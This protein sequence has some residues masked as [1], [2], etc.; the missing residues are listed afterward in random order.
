MS[1]KILT[2]VVRMFAAVVL[3]M[4]AFPAVAA[5]QELVSI[6]MT[7][8][9]LEQ[10]MHSIE[11]QTDYVFLNKDIDVKQ[12]VSINVTAKSVE[13]TLKVLFAG[14]D[15]DFRIESAHIVLF[16]KTVKSDR[17][18]QPTDN[19]VSGTVIDATGYPVI[20]V[21]VLIKGT[22]V[23]TSTDLDGKFSFVLPEGMESSS[24][25]FSC[26]GYTTVELPIGLRRVFDVTMQDDA[27]VME[28]TVVTALG[29]KRSEKALSYNVQQVNADALVAN[30]DA[31]FINSLNGKVA[32]LNINASSSGVGGA[33]K[34]VMRGM[35]SISQS[36]NALYVIDGVPMYSSAGEGGTQFDSQGSSDP[37]ADMNPDDIES[38]SVLT[39]AAA[40]AL[41]GS[42]AA[43]GAIVITTKK[44]K[45]GKLSVTASAGVEI[46]NPFVLPRFQNRYGTGDLNSSIGSDLRSWGMLMNE[47]NNP[48]YNPAKDYF[49]TGVT[50]T[51]SVA[52]STGTD[53]NQTYLSG[54]AIDSEGVVPNNG[55][56]RYNFTFR[57]TTA[58][59][60]D[61]MHLD[62]GF[63]Y[64]LQKDRNMTNQGTYNNPLVGA[65]IFP[66]SGDWDAVKMY[67][68][69]D[70][71]RRLSTQY[72]PIGDAG[73]TMQ[74]PYWINYRNLREN[75]KDRYMVNAALSYDILDWLSV[76]GR[77]RLD[78]SVTKYTEKFYA[79]TF[80]QLTELSSNG[81]YGI[82]S[83]KDRQIYA[84]ALININKRFGENWTLQANIGASITDM[85]Y[86]SFKNRGPIADGDITSERAGLANV[87]S[88][89]NL[90]NSAKTTRMQEGWREQTQSVFGSAEVGFKGTYYLTLTARNDWPSQLAGPHSNRKSFFYPSVGASVVLSQIIPNMPANLEYIK[91]RGSYA[92][93][94]TAFQ[95][96]IA[97]PLFSWNASSL[98][99]NTQTMYKMYD[100]KP[101]LT[102]SFEVGLTIRFL[103]WFNLDATYYHTNTLNQTFNPQITTG[104]GTSD[105]YIQS[106]DVLNQ[107]C[108]LSLGFGKDWNKFRWDSNFTFS[109]NMNKIMSLAN[110]I[111]NYN[112]GEYFSVDQLD[113]DGLGMAHFILREG[114][115]LGDLYSFADFKYDS[116]GMIV[117]NEDGTV[118]PMTITDTK[119][120]VKLGSVLPKANLSWRNDFRIGNFNFGFLV[121][122]RIGG[123]V[124]SSTQAV[125]DYY[126]V[127]EASALARDN[128]GV[129]INGGDL[130]DANKWYSSVG[131]SNP[132]PQEY[133]YS[134][135]NVRLQ[136][137]SIGYTFPRKMLGNVCDLNLSIVGRNL[138][139]IYNKAPFDPEAVAT[140]GNYYQGIDHFMMPSL[141]NFGF[142]VKVTF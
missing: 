141:R 38:I 64:I 17:G 73:M 9:P 80:T 78:N 44:G 129:Y 87:F 26:L 68:R 121:T 32:G 20:G 25:E 54:S 23:G 39:G 76:S 53:K 110:N 30:K 42:D 3:F 65:Y 101:E 16:R 81:L 115:T 82:T 63:S 90:S 1:K 102:N 55:Y 50:N 84:D 111:Y 31:N 36:S 79:T 15:V 86:D 118:T 35:K 85:S 52:V 108:E 134:A 107:G 61:K 48:K 132:L 75:R 94:G 109:T 29:I 59:L 4:G 105:I 120:Y 95:R 56:H 139:M 19:T 27:I 6:K 2:G 106:G 125:L 37:I 97:N 112:T 88:V 18:G 5:G 137:A 104:S 138:W 89:Q 57:N 51:E 127:S 58:F 43:N 92:S 7:D 100:L 130:V 11:Q 49:K 98:G 66:R 140:I 117:V 103:K 126:G 99:W 142:N 72:W 34:V 46:F 74:N 62:V 135:T 14:K 60:K 93:V 71:T 77:V 123:I 69:Y 83:Y 8:V 128:G 122:A 124:Y 113:M 12:K 91:I 136:E 22:T 28:A 33:T 41:Y 119:Q 131:G 13:E 116:N 96:Y 40:A 70:V 47:S 24:L 45:A 133:T 67:E 21:G 114:G 10:V